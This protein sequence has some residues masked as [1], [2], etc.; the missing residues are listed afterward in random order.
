MNRLF[1]R[2]RY[3]TIEI[4]LN[5][6]EIANAVYLAVPLERE[7]NVWG[8]EIYFEVPVNI[9]MPGE[10]KV[11][12]VGEVAYWP[13]GSAFCIFFGRTPASKGKEPEAYSPVVPIGKVVTN[14]EKLE[15][16]ADKTLVKLDWS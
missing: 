4:E 12:E 9:A 15:E 7:I 6:S 13:Q 10:R 2:T 11:M 14:L 5:D 1:M 3:D 16:L 8:G